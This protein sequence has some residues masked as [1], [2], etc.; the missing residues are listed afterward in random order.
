VIRYV[1][2]VL[3]MLAFSAQA[4]AL[5][6]QQVRQLVGVYFKMHFSH[7]DFDDELSR[8]TLDNFI[9][10]WDPGK[11]YFL[12]SDVKAMEEKY[13]TKLDDMIMDSDC[14]AIEE[15]TKTYT[16]RFGERQ[17]VIDAQIEAKHD[18][19]VDEYMTI[20]RKKM[21]YAAT[22][23]EIAERWRQR[24]KFQ[25]L[26][27]NNT[28]KD[29]PK[30]REKLR[31]RYALGVKRNAE[32]TSDDMYSAFL[33]A[34]SSSLD[35]HSE[36]YSPEQLEDFRISTSLHLDGIGAVLRSEDGFTTIQELVPGGPAALTG[37]V[38]EGDKIIAVAQGEESPVDVIDMDHPRPGS[39]EGPRGQ[40][41]GPH[42]L[43]YGKWHAQI[44]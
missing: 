39:A 5:N 38:N 16:K 25:L 2:V 15:I 1:F 11:V 34:F 43:G 44:L 8:R 6:C 32:L 35:P 12:K 33:N 28:M 36:Y 9:K 4:S 41:P 23:E 40:V 30:A 3:G 24:V 26:Q 22:T 42:H 27:L 10:S 29:L 21:D 17:K 13:A 37:K 7:H 20:D 31:K 19:T 14:R 18:F